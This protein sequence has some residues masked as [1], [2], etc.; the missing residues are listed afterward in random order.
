M[1]ARD[2]FL[3]L[4]DER[5]RDA[6]A[7]FRL[8]R[9]DFRVGAATAPCIATLRVHRPRFFSRVL[10]YGNLGMG[11]AFIDGDFTV[12]QGALT[13][14]LTALLR[15]RVGEGLERQPAFLLRAAG[16]RLRNL[17]AGAPRSV[18]AHYDLGVEL[19]ESFLDSSLTYSCGYALTPGDTL[20]QLQWQKL[21]RICR[22]LRLEPGRRLLDIGCGFGGLLIHA[23]THHGVTGVGVTLSR[24]QHR[25]AQQRIAAAGLADRLTV[26]LADFAEIEGPFDRIVSVGMI[27]HLRPARYLG[28]FRHIASSLA[29]DGVGLVHG[30]GR[31]TERNVQDAFI[32]KYV[33]PRS[34]TPSLSELALPL[35]QSGLAIVDADNV[36]PHYAPT[37]RAWLDRFLQNRARLDQKLYDPYFQRMWEYY[38]AC[39][40]AAAV[41]S[42][43]AV[44]QVL[45]TKDYPAQRWSHRV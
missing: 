36:G 44:F 18:R 34:N 39:G 7:V 1:S 35:E 4:L 42:D 38:L 45:F 9:G 21:D 32:Q 25:V 29:S 41:A 33:F 12:E 2:A 16:I 20:E 11:E 6:H 8:D 3:R 30:I 10:G 43:A 26:R 40:L 31:T 15:N 19:F 22:K 17:V 23:A 27:E 14:F 37:L 13:G 28:Y 5:L 24:D